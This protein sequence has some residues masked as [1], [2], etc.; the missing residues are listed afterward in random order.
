[1]KMNCFKKVL[2]LKEFPWLTQENMSLIEGADEV[3]I[4]KVDNNLLSLV[5][6]IDSY[7]WCGGGHEDFCH[8]YAVQDNKV[9]KLKSSATWSTGSGSRGETI[10][11]S[12]G[13]QLY[14]QR[15]HPDYIVVCEFQDTDDNGN[16]QEH[17]SV[18][19]YKNK[20]DAQTRYEYRQ[21]RRAY[22]ALRAETVPAFRD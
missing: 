6:W 1:M 13:E 2:L 21:L 10:A 12:I 7:D 20:D 15:L 4:K 19:I 9:S 22:E 18:V 3:Q 14:N 11:P 16:G 8:T 17:L 5:P